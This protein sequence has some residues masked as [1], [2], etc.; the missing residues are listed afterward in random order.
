MTAWL[1][2]LL[3]PLLAGVWFSWRY[4]WWRPPVPFEQPRILMY[5]MIRPAIPGAR[6]NKMR[7]AP[8][9]F[10]AQVAWLAQHGWTFCFV[11]ELIH[12]PHAPGQRRVALT[13]DDGYRDN[14]LNALPVLQEFRAKATLYPVAERS[15][16]FDWSSKKKAART[17]GE[18]GREPK[19]SDAEIAA[20]LATGLVEL[21]G[22]GL[23]HPN[24]PQ[25]STAEA[26]REI[27]GCKTA[28]EQTFRVPVPTF[29]YPFGLYGKREIELVQRAGYI[30]ATTTAEGVGGQDPF[31]F[32]RIKVSGT[33]GLFAFRLRLRTG[34]RSA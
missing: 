32:P 12:T 14:Y 11:S 25:L 17:S 2:L 33:E 18:L 23:T 22:H 24:L 4:A 31:Q 27:A 3:P 16:G 34:R 30:G 29:C 13:F 1:W 26:E 10:R 19:L 9:T 5:H 20:M 8:E 28:L 21:G 7:V 15:E 6:F